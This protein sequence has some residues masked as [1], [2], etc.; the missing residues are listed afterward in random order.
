[1]QW[2]A[3]VIAT[4]GFSTKTE[5]RYVN[6]E[7]NVMK[8]GKLYWLLGAVMTMVTVSSTAEDK[9]DFT[10][11]DLTWLTEMTPFRGFFAET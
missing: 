3:F 1:M 4:L 9:V 10:A 8:T 11:E 5:N 2:L 6:Y 7:G